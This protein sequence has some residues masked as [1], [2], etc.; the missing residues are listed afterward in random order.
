VVTVSGVLD[1]VVRLLEQQLHD[2]NPG[3]VEGPLGMIR[4]VGR[5]F[6]PHPTP[7]EETLCRPSTPP[8]LFSP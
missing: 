7:V 5:R 6:Q 8:S 3:T 1:L 2:D 4:D